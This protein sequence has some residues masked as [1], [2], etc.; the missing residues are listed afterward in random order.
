[1]LVDAGD[2]LASMV[3]M[4]LPLPLPLPMFAEDNETEDDAIVLVDATREE[5]TVERRRSLRAADVDAATTDDEF[6]A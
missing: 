3:G 6:I 2:P 4:W 1:M 5:T